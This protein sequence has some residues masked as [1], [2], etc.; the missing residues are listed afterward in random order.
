MDE[1]SQDSLPEMQDSVLGD[2]ELS[3]LFRDYRSCAAISEILVKT[4]PGYVQQGSNPTLDQVEQ[5]LAARSVRGVQVRYQFKMTSWCDTLMPM[6]NGVR[7]VR[8]RQSPP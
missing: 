5:L 3:A 7:L 2:A 6:P 8:I 4:G 1:A